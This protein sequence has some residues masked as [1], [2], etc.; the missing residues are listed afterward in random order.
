MDPLSLVDSLQL[1]ERE[2][3]AVYG[4]GGKTSLLYRLSRELSGLKKKVILTTTTKIYKPGKIPC[5]IC[6][7]L[8][9]A[10]VELRRE[11]LT[12]DLVALGSSLLPDNKLTGSIHHG[13]RRY[14]L[15]GQPPIFLLKLMA[16]Q[17]TGKRLRPL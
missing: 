10:L 17:E 7:E 9:E 2:I 12:N 1:G 3:V 11:L 15:A 5:V 4:A 6:S 8:R 14:T 13:L 16:L